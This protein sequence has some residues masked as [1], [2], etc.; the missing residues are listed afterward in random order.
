MARATTNA[1]ALQVQRHEKKKKAI[2]HKKLLPAFIGITVAVA[3][4]IAALDS[5]SPRPKRTSILTGKRW[6]NGL[7][8]GHP[9]RFHEQ[10]G[11]RKHVFQLL[12]N[13]LQQRVARQQ[14]CHGR[15]AAGHI[16]VSCTDWHE[17]P[18]VTR[19]FPAKWSYNPHVCQG[20]L[21]LAQ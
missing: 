15:G 2:Q 18:Y 3:V 10:M 13:E 5:P 21:T 20:F 17:F 6:I 8:A 9:E 16:P 4:T 7:I 19:A 11:M 1:T 14:I 12:L